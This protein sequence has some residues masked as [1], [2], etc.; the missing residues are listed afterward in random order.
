[1]RAAAASNDDE[2]QLRV[3]GGDCAGRAVVASSK[4]ESMRR[5][6]GDVRRAQ[7]FRTSAR[8]EQEL[9]PEA[10]LARGPHLRVTP[11]ADRR[12]ASSK[13]MIFLLQQ[14]QQ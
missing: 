5:Q 14:R 12:L 10:G 8:L 9:L 6:R 7:R 2:G 4:R 11:S 3:H 13:F 1:M